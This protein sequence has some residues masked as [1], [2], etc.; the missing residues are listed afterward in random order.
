[1]SED[2]GTTVKYQTWSAVDRCSQVA[3]LRMKI[4][5]DQ[6]AVPDEKFDRRS[7]NVGP[8]IEYAPTRWTLLVIVACFTA[9]YFAPIAW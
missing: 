7:E 9:L 4:N 5:T 2:I 1:M 8:A 6:P 3:Y